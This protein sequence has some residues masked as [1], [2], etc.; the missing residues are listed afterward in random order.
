[1]PTGSAEGDGLSLG[2]LRGTLRDG[3]MADLLDLFT[4]APPDTPLLDDRADADGTTPAE[5]AP[6]PSP[7]ATPPRLNPY[8]VV[9]GP[10]A[11]PTAPDDPFAEVDPRTL[12]RPRP[13]P[14]PAP[15]PERAPTSSPAPSAPPRPALQ[16]GTPLLAATQAV[17][18]HAIA[19]FDEQAGRFL[20]ARVPSEA[21]RLL[22]AAHGLRLAVETFE[23]ALPERAARRLVT[24]LR[25][26]VGA[27]DAALD[28]ARLAAVSGG[29]AVRVR[30]AADALGEAAGRLVGTRDGWGDR[31]RR[32]VTRL[33]AQAADGARRSDDAPVTDDFVGE[34]GDAPSATRLRHVLGSAIWAR[35]EAIRAFEDDLDLPTPALA[36]HLAVALSGLRYVLDLAAPA[37]DASRAISTALAT[38]ERTVVDARQRTEAGD[39]KALGALMEVWQETTDPTF[40]SR[41]GAVV[42]SV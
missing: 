9:L 13:S 22:V 3:D 38:A 18:S 2:E 14:A 16:G 23:G 15:T 5:P 37:G 40:R 17:V 8:P 21:R 19:S 39:P 33:A 41:L 36:S 30:A 31:A 28:A 26:L 34:P 42:A 1:V 35:F 4:P 27:L 32:L 12:R 6:A 29:D 20:A 10:V 11:A 25:P 7:V 24:A